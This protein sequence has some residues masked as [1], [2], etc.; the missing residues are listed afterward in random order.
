[1]VTL[2]VY[3]AQYCTSCKPFK[4][5]IENFAA[6]AGHK[7]EVRDIECDPVE[8]NFASLPTT[9]VVSDNEQAVFAGAH[10]YDAIVATIKEMV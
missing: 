10:Q 3:T 7:L 2:I 8:H 6:A 4:A 5:K 1:M 9:V